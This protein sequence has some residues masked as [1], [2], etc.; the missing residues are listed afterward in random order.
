ME[1]KKENKSIVFK[2]L[3]FCSIVSSFSFSKVEEFGTFGQLYKATEE[4]LIAMLESEYKKVDKKKLLENTKKAYNKSFI[5]Q[6]NL[7]TCTKTQVREFEPIIKIEKDIKVPIANVVIQKK[8]DNNNILK[9]N[10]LYF[11]YYVVFIDADD[12]NQIELAKYLQNRALILVAKGNI[13]NL[14]LQDM[15]AKVARE[16]IELAALKV[17]CLPSVYTQKDFKFIIN[18]YIP[19]KIFKEDSQ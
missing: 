4:N 2:I 11:P 17:E 5:I 12:K 15:E 16:N 9:E 6:S 8:H 19:D 14:L 10:N 18:E 7:K 3:L 13:K 1:I